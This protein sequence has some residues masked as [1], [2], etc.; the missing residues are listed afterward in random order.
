[1]IVV[2]AIVM[3]LFGAK[4]L[5]DLAKG[6]G[7]SIKEFKRASQETPAEHAARAEPAPAAVAPVASAPRLDSVEAPQPASA[8]SATNVTTAGKN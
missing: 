2:F 6:L 3:L 1:M 5:P 4:K 8:T 7:T